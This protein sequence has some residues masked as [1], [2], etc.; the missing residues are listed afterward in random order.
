MI[1]ST[2]NKFFLEAVYI[3]LTSYEAYP[4]QYPYSRPLRVCK[5]CHSAIL[6]LAIAW[7]GIVD[8]VDGYMQHD[9]DSIPSKE[10]F[11]LASWPECLCWPIWGLFLQE[12]YR[13]LRPTRHHHLVPRLRMRESW[14]SLPTYVF[15]FYLCYVFHTALWGQLLLSSVLASTVILGTGSLGTLTVFF[16]ITTLGAVDSCTVFN[17]I[18]INLPARA[19]IDWG[20]PRN[21][22]G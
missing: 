14:H 7:T 4:G 20:R 17:V 13:S 15:V 18:V 22:L 9:R 2:R 19:W 12:G 5:H 8:K 10:F 11:S 6:L 1:C 21:T 16:C 3:R